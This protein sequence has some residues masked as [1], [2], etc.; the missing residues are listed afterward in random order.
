[1]MPG[2]HGSAAPKE[3]A[4]LDWTDE[5][6]GIIEAIVDSSVR[7]NVRWRSEK[8]ARRDGMTKVQ[9]RHVREFM[10]EFDLPFDDPEEA[11]TEVGSSDAIE[12]DAAALARVSRIPDMMRGPTKDRI[13]NLAREKGALRIDLSLVEEGLEVARAAMKDAMAKGGHPG[14]KDS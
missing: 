8:S 7:D 13:E 6:I 14:G 3:V 2:G 10:E 4:D 5:A 1:M 9:L 12:W 11:S